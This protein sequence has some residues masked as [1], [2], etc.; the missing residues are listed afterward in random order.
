MDDFQEIPD[1]SK[2]ITLITAAQMESGPYVPPMARI[3]LYDSDEWESFIDEWVSHCLKTKYPSVLRFTGANDRGIDV[4]GFAD[5]KF[6][7]GVWDNFQCKHYDSGIT[8][9]T[10]WPEIGKILW[11]SFN[12]HFAPP[13]AYYFVA[14]RGTGTSLTQL[15]ANTANLKSRLIAAWDKNVR[16][17]I[18]SKQSV[19]LE[20]DFAAYVEAFDF[21]IFKPLAPREVVEQHRA[22]PYFTK[23][24]GGGLPARPTPGAPPDLIQQ[25]ESGYVGQLL[26]AYSDHTKE[27]VADLRALKKWKPLEQHFARQRECFYHAESLRV[28]VRD[29]VEPGTYEGLQEEVYQGVVDVCDSE[30]A[31][32]FDRVKSVTEAAQSL[33]LD[34]HPLGPS[35]FIKDKRGICHQLA[36][37]DRLKWTK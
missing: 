37:E 29:K 19:P 7:Q 9:G 15:L 14:P 28:F 22:S 31:D 30:H 26:A 34:A 24:F 25:E 17:A 16:D 33:P 4:A 2:P 20:D 27:T 35:A 23:R 5:D 32:G 12:G 13:R 6:L 8:P 3:L 21:S 36:N 11:H 1:P 10:A 18:T